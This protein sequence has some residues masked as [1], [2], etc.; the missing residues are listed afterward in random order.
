MSIDQLR[1][2]IVDNR[3]H[4]VK[5]SGERLAKA[6]PLPSVADPE[7]HKL[8]QSVQF[9]FIFDPN[10]EESW[11]YYQDGSFC[12]SYRICFGFP[13]ASFSLGYSKSQIEEAVDSIWPFSETAQVALEIASFAES[14]LKIDIDSNHRVTF[15]TSIGTFK[16]PTLDDRKKMVKGIPLLKMVNSLPHIFQALNLPFEAMS[17]D[18]DEHFR[19]MTDIRIKLR[20]P[21]FDGMTSRQKFYNCY[22]FANEYEPNPKAYAAM[23]FLDLQQPYGENSGPWYK[24]MARIQQEVSIDE[25]VKMVEMLDGN[26]AVPGGGNAKHYWINRLAPEFS[27][28]RKRTE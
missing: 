23:Q 21:L 4:I 15:E 1:Q 19:A 11:E 20:I 24:M 28:K 18:I 22:D 3:K 8:A 5:I 2:S 26:I 10:V 7:D 17:P 25:L 6:H 14:S 16:N 12:G 27:L 13:L 9:H